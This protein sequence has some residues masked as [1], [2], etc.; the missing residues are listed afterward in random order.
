MWKIVGFLEKF[1]IGAQHAKKVYEKFGVSSIEKIKEDPYLLIEIARG[2]DF[3]QIDEMAIRIGI[4]PDNDRRVQTGIKYGLIRSTYNGNSCVLEINLIEYVQSLLDV[5]SE[6]IED[7]L[8]ALKIKGEIVYDFRENEQWVYLARFFDTEK[9]I[10]YR[11][12]L[13]H[14]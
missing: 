8:I 7:N 5:S 6:T 13:I 10:A 12:S 1:H 3:R 2:V 4:T 9:E 14:I 11:L